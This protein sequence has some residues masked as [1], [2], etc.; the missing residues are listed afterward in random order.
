MEKRTTFSVAFYARRTRLNKHGEAV[1]MLRISVNRMRADTT[2]KRTILPELWDSARGKARERTPLAKE[3]NMYMET[4][5]AKIVRIHREMETDGVEYITAQ[6]VLDKY[7]GRDK[8]TRHTLVEVFQEHNEKCKALAGIDMS[9]ATVERYETCLRHTIDFMQY[10]YKKDD[11]FLDEMSRQFI[12][13]YEFYMKTVRKCSH[14]T[15]TK[16]LKNFKKIT[17]IAIQKEWLKKDPF[18]D[19]RFSLQQV[20]RDFLESHEI[21]KMLKKEIDIDRLAQVRDVF[22][23]CCF[24]GLAFSDVKQLTADHISIDVNGVKWIRKPRQK[25]KNMCNIPLMEIPL[26]LIEKYKNDTDCQAKGV[27]LP[28]LCNQKMNAYIKEIATICG[29]KKQVS[30][31]TARHTFGTYMLANGVSI[32]N[33]AKMLGHSDTK[34]TRHYAKVLDQTILNEV[35]RISPGF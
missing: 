20:E 30:T 29:I 9:P 12:E 10:T 8:P 31:H 26:K 33:V 27:L 23:F 14:N 25:T 1:V 17:R 34:M 28:V 16:Y 32:E 15:T 6:M 5:R 3:L 22:I 21:E 2:I 19:I 18:S 11:I 24:T 35:S 13:D 7:L 4:I